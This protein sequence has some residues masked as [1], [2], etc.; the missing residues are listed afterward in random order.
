MFITFIYLKPPC[1]VYHLF[2]IR[3]SLDAVE[4][5]QESDYEA[6]SNDE[7]S[8]NQ[9]IHHWFCQQNSVVEYPIEDYLQDLHWSNSACFLNL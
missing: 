6:A 4:N 7:Y 5:S 2:L 8:S 3:V 9:L 1:I